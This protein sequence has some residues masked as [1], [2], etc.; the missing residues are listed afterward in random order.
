MLFLWFF[1]NIDREYKLSANRL[2]PAI[3]EDLAAAESPKGRTLSFADTIFSMYNEHRGQKYSIRSADATLS[4]A[5]RRQ[6]DFAKK[7]LCR[8]QPDRQS[9][10]SHLGF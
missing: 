7:L 4:R 9:G 6:A 10:F 8:R 2:Q 5:Y 3:S 1:R